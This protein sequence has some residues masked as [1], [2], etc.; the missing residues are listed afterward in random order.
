MPQSAEGRV[1]RVGG[2]EPRFGVSRGLWNPIMFDFGESEELLRHLFDA[3]AVLAHYN[4]NDVAAN[5]RDQPQPPCPRSRA[6]A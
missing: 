5:A 4:G 2:G 3:R 6:F 1:A